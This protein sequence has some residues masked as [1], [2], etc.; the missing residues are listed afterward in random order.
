[1]LIIVYL[2]CSYGKKSCAHPIYSLLK[3]FLLLNILA[4]L[5]VCFDVLI[6][7]GLI[8]PVT[9]EICSFIMFISVYVILSQSFQMLLIGLILLAERSTSSQ[10][11]SIFTCFRCLYADY[12]MTELQGPNDKNFTYCLSK[13]GRNLLLVG[14]YICAFIICWIFSPSY[15]SQL[16]CESTS[17]TITILNQI[18]YLLIFCF[19]VFFFLYT[20][21]VYYFVSGCTRENRTFLGNLE[22]ENYERIELVRKLTIINCVLG[23]VLI[24]VAAFHKWVFAFPHKWLILF[25]LLIDI[26]GIFSIA[27]LFVIHD[28]RIYRESRKDQENEQALE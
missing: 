17:G 5:D 28:R 20:P 16:G 22:L 1:M 24:I 23:L 27:L 14:F 19:F 4:T 3:H 15:P 26:T 11:K 12:E 10:T 6:T 9:S 2:I 7:A 21:L 8:H 18:V 25:G 13:N